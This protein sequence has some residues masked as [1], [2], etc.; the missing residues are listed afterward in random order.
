MER[1]SWAP[2]DVDLDRPSIARVY[3]SYLGG[4]HNFEVDRALAEHHRKV[5]PQTPV[6]V[7]AN[8]AFL[9]RAVRFCLAA[10]VRQFLDIGSGIPTAG[11]VHEVAQQTDPQARV[12]YVDIDPIAVSHSRAI[13]AGNER[14]ATLQADLRAPEKIMQD[15]ELRAL[16]DLSQPVAL[17]MVAVLHF[18]PDAEGP[19]DII[20]RFQAALAPGSFLVISHACDEGLDKPLMDDFREEYSRAVAR[21]VFRTQPEVVAL[22]RGFTLVE[23]GV[24]SMAGWRPDP[25]E[26]PG[27]ALPFGYAGV[28]RKP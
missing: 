3:D 28:G 8:R 15:P 11:N 25:P 26:Q 24:V 6:I 13:L 9:T 17:L 23:P 14:T 20:D 4:F 7:R 12:V 16:L 19:A 1:P 18:V 2:P 21:I 5:L 27:A 10:G 22:F